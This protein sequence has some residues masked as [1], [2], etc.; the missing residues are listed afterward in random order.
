MPRKTYTDDQI[1]K[2]LK[3]AR[4]DSRAAAKQ[5]G[6]SPNTVYGRGRKLGLK[7]SSPGVR[8]RAEPK[9]VEDAELWAAYKA[10]CQEA[11]NAIATKYVPLARTIVSRL[12]GSLPPEVDADDLFGA[13]LEGLLQAMRKFEPERGFKFNTYAVRRIRGAVIDE[14]RTTD[15]VPRLTR[16][17]QRALAI[18]RQYWAQEYGREPTDDEVLDAL[19]WTSQ[20]VRQAEIRHVGSLDAV[21]YETEGGRQT[22][23]VDQ[24][25]TPPER[26]HRMVSEIEQVTRGIALEPRIVMWLYFAFGDT[27]KEIGAKLYLSESRVSQLMSTGLAE[28]RKSQQLADEYQKRVNHGD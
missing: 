4:G 12:K 18:M 19:G 26:D 28:L 25:V 21:R 10:G 3:R 20:D 6:C 27:M 2:A 14:L 22:T 24:Y 15:F 7:C 11:A 5:L 23:A 8:K 17:K 16:K 9:E 1:R 13:A